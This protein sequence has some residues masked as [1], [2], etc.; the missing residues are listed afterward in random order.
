MLSA[1][2]TA[3]QEQN[4]H[5]AVASAIAPL[6]SPSALSAP[7]ITEV[8]D[9]A[10]AVVEEVEESQ[11]LAWP[12]ILRHLIFQAA[13]GATPPSGTRA[14]G[15]IVYVPTLSVDAALEGRNEIWLHDDAGALAARWLAFSEQRPL[16]SVLLLP[17]A[18][19]KALDSG[20]TPSSVSAADA[21]AATRCRQLSARIGS[22]EV[23]ALAIEK[24]AAAAAALA[25]FCANS[26]ACAVVLE[27][28]YRPA[29]CAL[30]GVLP[31]VLRQCQSSASVFVVTSPRLFARASWPAIVFAAGVSSPPSNNSSS[32]LV[33]IDL[34]LPPPAFADRLVSALDACPLMRVLSALPPLDPLS[35]IEVGP[36]VASK[37]FPQAAESAARLIGVPYALLP[38]ESLIFSDSTADSE[39]ACEHSALLR[40]LQRRA[41]VAQQDE[42][43]AKA[44]NGDISMSQLTTRLAAAAAAEL[45]FVGTLVANASTPR[46]EDIFAAA[47]GD[48][49]FD[50]AAIACR[51]IWSRA[52]SG[53]RGGRGISG[54]GCCCTIGAEAR[55]IAQLAAW[56][57][58]RIDAG[59]LA[60]FAAAVIC[61]GDN[62]GGDTFHVS[63]ELAWRLNLLAAMTAAAPPRNRE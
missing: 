57:E 43:P 23:V 9:E 53:D 39:P 61:G 34:P 24:P 28:S 19:L 1:L 27:D 12:K 60:D 37:G 44:L 62:G 29:A 32:L 14:P 58:L 31:P 56:S 20:G 13:A 33:A 52:A 21:A 41:W 11:P 50:A 3:R 35:S 38:R 42:A 6:L 48:A 30:A 26:C 8:I 25:C 2:A 18:V 55:V 22:G 63:G 46:W 40:C 45:H 17:R 5:V 54:G 49:D 47:T 4:Q 15:P 59:T 36:L 10:I 7:A 51:Q 16:V